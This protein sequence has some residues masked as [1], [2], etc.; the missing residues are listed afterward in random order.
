MKILAINGSYRGNRGQ[1]G[2]FLKL[3]LSGATIAG[4]ECEEVALAKINLQHC[5]GCDTCHTAEHYLSCVY[6][7]KDGVE[8]VFRKIAEA[9][10]VIYATPVYVFGI[11]SLM[12]TFLDRL[13]S[14][15]DVNK[16][17]VTRSGLFFHH[18]DETVCSK[19]FVSLIC[20]DNLDAQMP[21]NVRDYFRT[22]A[23]FMDAN[24]AGELIRN[25]ARL[26]GD[27]SSNEHPD[28]FPRIPNVINAYQQ[29]GFELATNGL[30]SKKT[31]RAANQEIIPVP[32]FGWLK[33]LRPFKRVMVFQAKDILLRASGK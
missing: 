23:R 28:I 14:T 10:L 33:R 6:S 24:Q 1:T 3:L 7:Q 27:L 21:V 12:K 29:A 4:A 31:Q 2:G 15:S 30:I 17:R 16:L 32:G 19:P 18:V 25:G 13:Y 8:E 11:S 20:C 9:D 22:Y 26:F 5:L